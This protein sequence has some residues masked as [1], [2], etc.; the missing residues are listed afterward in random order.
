MRIPP[1]ERHG[2]GACSK[3]QKEDDAFSKQN[4]LT[5]GHAVVGKARH[6]D[7]TGDHAYVVAPVTYFAEQ[8]GKDVQQLATGTFALQKSAGVGASQDGPIARDEA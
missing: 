3:W 7:I 2:S 1:Y 6:I 8:G 4:G 5:D